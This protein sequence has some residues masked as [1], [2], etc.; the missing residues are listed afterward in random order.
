MKQRYTFSVPLLLVLLTVAI[1]KAD[2]RDERIQSLE[3]R[4]EQLEKLLKAQDAKPAST[5][6]AEAPKPA[7]PT[8]PSPSLSVGASGFAL[9]SA[10][11]NFVLRIRGLLQLDSRWS[12][13]DDL[14]D[15][16]LVRRARPIIEGTVFRDFDFRLTPEFGTSTPTI[17]DAW[18][19]YRYD[20]PLELRFGKMK[21][22]GNLERWQGAANTL[23]IERALPSLLWPV[24]EVGVM[25]HGALWPGEE[26]AAKSLAAVGLVN[27]QLGIF[28]GTG[29]ARA[30]GNS[31]FDGDKTGAGRLFFHPFLR[32]GVEPLQKLGLGVSGTYGEMEGDLGLPDDIE[33]DGD[34]VADG[35][36]WRVGPQAYWYWGQFGLMGEYSISSQRLEQEVAPFASTRAENSAWM[37]T[38]SWMLT[39]EDATFRAV[40]PRKNFDPRAGSWGAWQV[41]ARYSHLDLDDGLFPTF[42]DP[43]ELP[44]SA[45]NWGFGLNWYL[46]RNVRASFNYNHC[47]FKGGQGSAIGQAENLFATR[48]QLVF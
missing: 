39:G 46:N 28:N 48:V 31:D 26:D 41:V 8:K 6:P 5:P 35:L 4:V 33:Y 10:D 22:P 34:V 37:V 11:S 3:K 24:R 12:D 27:Y 29:D 16:F 25:V 45:A 7:E 40:T 15:S 2:D 32:S 13:D 9:R 42:A 47:D 30:A 20:D 44:T 17:R 23:F 38:A 18:L 19:N 1:A 43:A 21:S 36:H 14:G